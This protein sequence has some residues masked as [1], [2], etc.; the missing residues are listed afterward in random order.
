MVGSINLDLV[1]RASHLPSAGET[2]TGATLQRHPGGKGANQAL[3]AE[4]LGAEVCLIGRVGNDAMAGEALALMES[5]GV[6]LSGV[7]TDVAA[8]TGVALIAVDPQGENQIVVAAGANH[9]LAIANDTMYGLGAGVWTRDGTRA[10]RFGRLINL[11]E[12]FLHK[13]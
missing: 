10:Y 5:I 7:E 8:P 2:V 11:K 6:D 12:P 3:A 13:R 9:S 4:K 1:A